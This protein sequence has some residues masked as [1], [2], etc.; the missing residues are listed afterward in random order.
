MS[1]TWPRP[2]ATAKYFPDWPITCG[3]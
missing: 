2:F 3:P 1:S